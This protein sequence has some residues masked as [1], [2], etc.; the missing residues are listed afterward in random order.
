MYILPVLILVALSVGFALGTALST[1][2]N[3]EARNAKQQVYALAQLAQG[4]FTALHT[5][6]V[7]LEKAAAADLKKIAN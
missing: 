5:R 3:S 6:I 7:E 4:N 2:V 1:W